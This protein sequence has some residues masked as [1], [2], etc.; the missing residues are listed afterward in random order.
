MENCCNYIGSIKYIKTLLRSTLKRYFVCKFLLEC[1]IFSVIKRRKS[2]RVGNKSISAKSR[3][4][5]TQLAPLGNC[6]QDVKITVKR[7]LSVSF[8]YV[9]YLW[10]TYH[11]LRNKR[12]DKL[13]LTMYPLEKFKVYKESLVKTGESVCK[14]K[15]LYTT[16]KGTYMLL[17]LWILVLTAVKDA[18]W[19]MVP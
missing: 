17:V 12:F 4:V 8:F 19:L 16:R 5:K 1:Y 15:N 10:N 13:N 9:D 14:G 18:F 6:N 11:A 7:F 3:S 2:F